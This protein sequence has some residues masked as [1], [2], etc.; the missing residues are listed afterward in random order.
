MIC[1]KNKRNFLCTGGTLPFYLE[2]FTRV[3]WASIG[4]QHYLR[5]KQFGVEVKLGRDDQ[6][7]K[8]Q[9]HEPYESPKGKQTSRRASWQPR[10][11]QRRWWWRWSPWLH[12]VATL[13]VSQRY[14]R[15]RLL[16]LQILF[17]SASLPLLFWARVQSLKLRDNNASGKQKNTEALELPDRLIGL[18]RL[19]F[20]ALCL[21]LWTVFFLIG[22]MAEGEPRGN[23]GARLLVPNLDHIGRCAFSSTP[24][25]NTAPAP[26]ERWSS[27]LS[28]KLKSSWC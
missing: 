26:M 2:Q 24:P 27:S 20:S 10:P 21:A 13:V 19:F 18:C 17:P 4:V 25:T 23:S 11:S 7:H 16:F 14:C 1:F 9:Q 5:K 12:L 3:V 22:A 8:K 6:Q 15:L 28:N